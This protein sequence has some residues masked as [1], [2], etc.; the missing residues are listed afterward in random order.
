MI[1]SDIQYSAAQEQV[2]MLT[3]SLAAPK[4]PEVPDAIEQASKAQI[5]DL[6][7]ELQSEMDEYDQL[8]SSD[9]QDIK[10]Q[11]INDLMTAPIRYRLATNMSLDSFGRKVCVSARQIARYEQESYRNTSS[12]TLQ[13]ILQALDIQLDG[14]VVCEQ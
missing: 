1:T 11:S 4:K 3:E 7:A 12:S 6:I 13:K 2:A 5:R 10:I 8:K 9:G 14:K